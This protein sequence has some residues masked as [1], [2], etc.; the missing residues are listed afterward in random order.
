MIII[1]HLK[2]TQK[3]KTMQTKLKTMQINK[4]ERQSQLEPLQKQEAQIIV[5]ME[6]ENKRMVK[7][8][9]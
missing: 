7:S 6:E 2:G 5:Q 4:Q 3:M 9:S 8:H 1:E